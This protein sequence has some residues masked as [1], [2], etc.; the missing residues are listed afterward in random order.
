MKRN[1]HCV[2][3]QILFELKYLTVKNFP[4]LGENI[5]SHPHNHIYLPPI[6]TFLND[7]CS[8]LVNYG[9]TFA[10]CYHI[11]NKIVVSF[12]VN[13]LW[14]LKAAFSLPMFTCFSTQQRCEIFWYFFNFPI[15]LFRLKSYHMTTNI[16][17]FYCKQIDVWL[18]LIQSLMH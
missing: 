2:F 3:H 15:K 7:Q 16:D 13:F 8:F 4:V 10:W 5:L 6:L 12:A 9:K 11:I 17:D 18:S 1:L 14:S